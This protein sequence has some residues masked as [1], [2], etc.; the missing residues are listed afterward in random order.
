MAKW[1]GLVL[2]THVLKDVRRVKTTKYG[3]DLLIKAK[4][5]LELQEAKGFWNMNGMKSNVISLFKWNR[6][7]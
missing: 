6:S 4:H 1:I 7:V 2:M 3:G 5:R